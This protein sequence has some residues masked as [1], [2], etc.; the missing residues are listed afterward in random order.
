MTRAQA[1]HLAGRSIVEVS[2]PTAGEFLQGLV[3]A[4][5]GGLAPGSA[6]NAALLTPQGKILFEFQIL[7]DGDGRYLLDGPRDAASELAKRLTFYRLR[8]RIDIAARPD[9]A[10]VAQWDGAAPPDG[11]YGGAYGDPRLD[12]LG[13]RAIVPAGDAA[14][15]AGG[16]HAQT[17]TDYNAHRIARGVAEFGS[18]YVSGA[19]FPHEANL[20][21]L[22][23]VDFTKGCFVGQEVVSRMQHRGTARS[24]FVPVAMDGLA[25]ATGTA[26]EAGGRQ[27]GIMGSSGA[28]RGL[29]LIRLDRAGEAMAAG[30]PIRCGEATLKPEKPAWATFD[31]PGAAPA[32]AP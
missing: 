17:E 4:D 14:A 12:A 19:V 24:R 25:P 6:R 7:N 9:Q 11:T 20:D 32:E 1:A 26:I 27:I 18:D 16:P 30:L 2:G 13:W 10:V 22:G 21:Q 15:M 3:T 28:G 8:A 23:G 5:V 31:L 29:A